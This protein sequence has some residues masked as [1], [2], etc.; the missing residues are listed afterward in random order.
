MPACASDRPLSIGF[1]AVPDADL[2]AFYRAVNASPWRPATP[3]AG[4]SFFSVQE[5]IAYGIPCIASSGGA[6]PEAGA[7]LAVSFDPADTEGLKKAMA[8]WITDEGA[9]AEARARLARELPAV[10]RPTWNDAAEA[11]LKHALG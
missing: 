2:A 10:R 6:L 1:C 5:S 11:L 7:G 9:L 4:A 3:K 8:R